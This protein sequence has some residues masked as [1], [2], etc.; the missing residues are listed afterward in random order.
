LLVHFRYEEVPEYHMCAQL[1]S[2]SE[3]TVGVVS[4]I[5]PKCAPIYNALHYT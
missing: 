1:L 5:G 2:D 3:E 4:E